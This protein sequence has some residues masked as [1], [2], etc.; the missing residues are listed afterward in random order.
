[1]NEISESK[2]FLDMEPYQSG[3][4]VRRSGS[5]E[6]KSLFSVLSPKPNRNKSIVLCSGALSHDCG[7]CLSDLLQCGRFPG[8]RLRRL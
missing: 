4:G 3:R 1:M 5:I 2:R 8:P 7:C 6:C